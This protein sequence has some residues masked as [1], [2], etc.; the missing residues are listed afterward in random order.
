MPTERV[1]E[2][3]WA[4][5][6]LPQTGTILDVGSCYA[7]YLDSILQPD[8]K[9]HCLDPYDCS[10]DMPEG[11]VF[12]QES[13][14]GNMLPRAHFD[15]VLCISTLEHIGLPCYGQS[16][17]LHGDELAVAEMWDLLKPGAPLIATVPAGTSK[18]MS[19]YRQYSPAKLYQLFQNFEAK[20]YY[21]ALSNNRYEPIEEGEVERYDYRDH[22]G[23][24]AGAVAG[25]I[26]YRY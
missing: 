25:I 24:G 12:H 11:I 22:P 8:R 14:I 17:F 7:T 9:L 21:W 13:L 2:I 16:P 19:W 1:V 23:A 4:L 18:V 20:F 15:A 6:H 3:P 10:K 26:A 5:M